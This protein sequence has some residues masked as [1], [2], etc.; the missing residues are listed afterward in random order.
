MSAPR[1]RRGDVERIVATIDGEADKGDRQAIRDAAVVRLIYSIGLRRFEV[2]QLRLEDV[3]L[4]APSVR[5]LRRGHLERESIDIGNGTAAALGRWIAERGKEPGWLFTRT[6]RCDDSR[7]LSGESIRRL[8]RRWADLA[9]VRGAVRP[10]GLRRS[11]LRAGRPRLNAIDIKA[12]R[13]QKL[14]P[15]LG[16]YE[17]C[18]ADVVLTRHLP[19][20]VEFHPPRAQVLGWCKIDSERTAFKVACDAGESV[21]IVT[22]D[23]DGAP[24]GHSLATRVE[25]IRV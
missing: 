4:A 15:R 13:W 24:D 6:D 11:A 7:P 12:L 25:V 2:G 23:E 19:E 1:P 8:L 17:D 20:L 10:H 3:D 18:N 22:M 21:W 16:N 9:G 14:D 5:P